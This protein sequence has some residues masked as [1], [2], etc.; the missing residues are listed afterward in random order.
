M[1]ALYEEQS[2][3]NEFPRYWVL[4]DGSY[5]GATNGLPA[6]DVLPE[7]IEVF[8]PPAYADQIWD[9]TNSVWLPY[10]LMQSTNTEN[11]WRDAELPIIADQLLMIEDEDPNALPGTAAQWRAYR[12]QVRAWKVGNTHFPNN[13]SRPTRPT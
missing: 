12:V 1:D 3:L 2:T 13:N 7:W 4:S 6:E 11:A 5:I 8:T 9:F 10:S